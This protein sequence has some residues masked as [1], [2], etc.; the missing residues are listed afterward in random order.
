MRWSRSLRRVA[1]AIASL[2]LGCVASSPR[3]YPLYPSPDGAR[4]DESQVAQLG[5]YVRYVDGADMSSH[6][7]SF[8][9]LPGCHVVGTPSTWGD[10]TSN[11][12]AVIMTTGRLTFALPMK[13]GYRY[14]VR[15]EVEHMT[16]P[17]GT[18]GIK[19]Y[20]S[21]GRGTTTRTFGP[22]SGAVDPAT[23]EEAKVPAP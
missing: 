5:G 4:P 2:G 14:T 22:T 17:T 10:A 18:G 21:D 6:G 7:T 15:A 19:A 12:A 16:G 13:S 8:E 1:P 9:V 23:C 11:T 20:E 3:G